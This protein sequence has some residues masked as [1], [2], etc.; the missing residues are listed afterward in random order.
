MKPGKH[1]MSKQRFQELCWKV[2][3]RAQTFV[4]RSYTLH[5]LRNQNVS[6]G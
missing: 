5:E 4:L 2:L 3:D 6:I 1:Q